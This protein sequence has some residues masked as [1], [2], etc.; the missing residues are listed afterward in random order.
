M[1][2]HYRHRRFY[3]PAD[4]FPSPI[5][6]GEIAVN[7]ANRQLAVGDASPGSPGAIIPLLAVRFFDVRSQYATSDY[8][9][10]GAGIYRAKATLAPGAFNAL[11]WDT[12]ITDADAKAYADAGDAGVSATLQSEIDSLAAV[13]AGKVERGGDTMQ[14]YL[15]LV[16]I[17][18]APLHA[19]TKKYVDDVVAA[20]GLV[21]LPAA[22]VTFVPGGALSSTNAQDALTELDAE[23]APLYSP[24]FLGSPT[25]QT[26][27]A[28]DNSLAIATTAWV[29]TYTVNYVVG[30]VGGYFAAQASAAQPLMN[31]VVAVGTSTKFAREDHCHPTDATRAPVNSPALT[32]V[33]TAPTANTSSNSQQIATTAFVANKFAGFAP[34]ADPAFTG[35][36][37]APTPTLGDNDTSIATTEFVTAALAA[38]A[39]SAIGAI[40]VP[41]QFLVASG[42]ITVPVGA[43]KLE[44]TL[45]G[46][47][48]G[49]SGGLGGQPAGGGATL[50]KFLTGLTAGNTLLLAIGAAVIGDGGDTTLKSGTQAITALTAGGGKGGGGGGNG[51]GGVA[52]NGDINI[53]GQA[54]SSDAG[55]SGNSLFGFGAS[56]GIPLTGYG[57]GALN[58]NSAGTPGL[59]ILRWYP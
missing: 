42:T 22:N 9:V 14:G 49:V 29:Q 35:N 54:A 17:P 58:G 21:T 27:P 45:Q 13:V 47:G 55:R 20:G 23:K 32:G 19:A 10:Q 33:P 5:E 30:Y 43:T 16:G 12:F 18:N 57:A 52:T 41:V 7:T 59:A 37:T 39:G 2:S 31:G 44:V 50:F 28:N 48:G 3:N 46:A 36:P 6:S 8:V 25:S 34:L 53:N 51:A 38:Q 26:P 24:A 56:S 40:A 15:T 11:Q 1:T 4:A